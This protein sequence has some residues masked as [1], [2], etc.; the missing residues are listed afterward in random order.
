MARARPLIAMLPAILVVLGC[1]GEAT[2]HSLQGEWVVSFR[3]EGSDLA[4]AGDQDGVFVFDPRIPCY[5]DEEVQPTPGAIGGRG[6]LDYRV[7]GSP[8]ES[9]SVQHF[10]HGSGADMTEEFEASADSAGHSRIWGVGTPLTMWGEME[11]D[12]VVGRWVFI[13][14]AATLG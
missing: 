10:L 11:A 14:R 5:C 2:S 1:Q 12:S 9:A 13:S 4:T 8:M 3:P 6:Y 7:L